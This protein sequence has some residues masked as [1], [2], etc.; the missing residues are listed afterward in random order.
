M[1]QGI[2]H[3]AI[4]SAN[5]AALAEW[6]VSTL[7][8]TINYRGT[9]A[10]FVRAPDGSMIE[11]IPAEGARTDQTLQ[12][13]GLRHLALTVTGFDAAYAE[14]K[15]RNVIFVSEPMESKGNKVVFF[16]DPEGNYLHLLE[17][18]APLP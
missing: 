13:P 1:I 6:Y 14:L 12:T 5:P 10:V 16:T 11:I 17:R 4:A 18:A 7:G 2:E 9:T 8:F 15:A 3:A